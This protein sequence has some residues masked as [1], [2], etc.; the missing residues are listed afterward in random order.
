MR[1]RLPRTLWGLVPTI[2]LGSPH[3]LRRDGRS[4]ADDDGRELNQ[5]IW[6]LNKLDNLG[7]FSVSRGLKIRIAP[8]TIQS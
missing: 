3:V 5:S 6:Y 1:V 4:L 8:F 2:L 7:G